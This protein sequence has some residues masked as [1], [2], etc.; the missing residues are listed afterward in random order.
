M[1]SEA[2][3]EQHWK[4]LQTKTLGLPPQFALLCGHSGS[5]LLAL[6]LVVIQN[7]GQWCRRCMRSRRALS[8]WS[9]K[10]ERVLHRNGFT[11]S[12]AELTPEH[13]LICVAQWPIIGRM[14]ATHDMPSVLVALFRA[15]PRVPHH[16]DTMAL[17]V[18]TTTGGGM[19]DV[20]PMSMPPSASSRS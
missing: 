13:L 14:D 3:H 11:H 6:L 8:N 10:P 16:C 2:C 20:P 15:R 4:Q 18:L 7:G 19:G 9:L 17:H 12:C 5:L 1:R